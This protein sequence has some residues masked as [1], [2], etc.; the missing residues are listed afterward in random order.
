MN[1]ASRD[2]SGG[3]SIIHTLDDVRT[4]ASKY[5]TLSSA[6]SMKGRWYCIGTVTY[7]SPKDR[8]MHTITNVVGY[9]HDTGCAFNGTCSCSRL[10]Q[11]CNGVSHPEKMDIAVGNFTG[12]GSVAASDFVDKNANSAPRSWQQIAG[13]PSG[14]DTSGP[15]GGVPQ[16]TGTPS[17]ASYNPSSVRDPYSLSYGAGSSWVPT[18]YNQGSASSV[19]SPTRS[20]GYTSYSSSGATS[21]YSYTTTNSNTSGVVSSNAATSSSVT[22]TVAQPSSSIIIAQP[23]NPAVGASVVLSWTSAGMNA[24]SCTVKIDSASPFSAGS[25]GTNI[26]PSITAGVHTFTY[27]CTT[28]AGVSV[29]TSTTVTAR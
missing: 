7:A 11:Y 13:L 4:G 29:A 15:C 23:A 20:G 2:A 28:A 6:T 5:V 12:W 24:G 18:T 3:S 19:A 21:G 25:E 16:E 8:Q 26:L 17:A 9:V 22:A 27:A 14:T 1:A 10:A